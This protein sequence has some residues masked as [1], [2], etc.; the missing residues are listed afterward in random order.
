M[1]KTIFHNWI[2]D[3]KK[4]EHDPFERAKLIKEHLREHNISQRELGR[5]MDIPHS[6][7]QDWLM[8]DRLSETGYKQMKDN[9][10]TDTDIYKTLRDNK[11][12]S[13]EYIMSR[14]K[15]DF[16]LTEAIRL[17]Q[18]AVAESVIKTHTKLTTSLI[19]EAK[20]LI[21]RIDM[22]RERLKK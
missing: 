4:K 21:N 3:L 12:Q 17:L 9:M 11:K 10:M 5:R 14:T 15:L 19:H 2:M 7:L 16:C 1:N 13:V 8:W 6:T 20:D 18:Q 22:R